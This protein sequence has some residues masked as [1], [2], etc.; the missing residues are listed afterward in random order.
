M[1]RLIVM[2]SIVMLGMS[3]MGQEFLFD[4]HGTTFG[5]LTTDY[6]DGEFVEDVIWE[7]EQESSLVF[8]VDMRKFIIKA[9]NDVGSVFY[10][11]KKSC[12]YNYLD[13]EDGLSTTILKFDAVDEEDLSCRVEMRTWDDI[14]Y[15]QLY[16]IYPDY[17]VCFDCKFQDVG[18]K[19]DKA[20]K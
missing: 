17:R 19:D 9:N 7:D 15:F 11:D 18:L 1:K 10:L 8:M 2:L 16:V 20:F 3:L 6:V 12:E 14:N 13:D 4:V 5:E